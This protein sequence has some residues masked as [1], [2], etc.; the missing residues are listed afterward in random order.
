LI[1]FQNKIHPV[2]SDQVLPLFLAHGDKTVLQKG[3]YSW[4]ITHKP[5]SKLVPET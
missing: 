1:F 2:G 3:A 5:P 4:V